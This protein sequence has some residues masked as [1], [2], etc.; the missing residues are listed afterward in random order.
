[1]KNILKIGLI[2]II[3]GVALW[4]CVP[5]RKFQDMQQRA[6]SCE[7][8][9]NDCERQRSILQTKVD[10]LNERILEL[11]EQV[12][13]L[14]RD[15][16]MAGERYRRINT[17]NKEL[18]RLYEDL[19]RQYRELLENC[20]AQSETLS[21]SLREKIEELNRKEEELRQLEKRLRDMEAE[22]I[23]RERRVKELERL[24][25]QKDSA[26]RAL[27]ERIQQ[28]LLGFGDQLHVQIR[29][30]KI[31]VTMSEKLLFKSGSYTVEPEGKKALE[32]IAQVIKNQSDF[33]VMVEGHTDNVPIKTKCIRDNWD[34]S[35]LRAT[36]VVRILT[37]EYGVDPKI[38][39][40][41]GRGEFDPV[42]PNDTPEGRAKNRRTEIILIPKVD[43]IMQL[44]ETK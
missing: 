26:L 18:Q 11:N 5:Y 36:S 3:A 8:R 4:Q 42:A 38:L 39:V 27:K 30:G 10:S 2:T 37:E 25:A 14:I 20:S 23:A 33:T 17:L 35:V 6:E 21:Q 7:S 32:Q 16:A 9:L 13:E 34:L 28:S 40:A 19:K 44:L 1:M 24:L 15:T 12:A 43:K 22:L 31:Y 29:D 41:A